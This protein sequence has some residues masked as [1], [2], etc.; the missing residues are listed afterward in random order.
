M[1]RLIGDEGGGLDRGDFFS[2]GFG[3]EA[4]IGLRGLNGFPETERIKEV[5]IT[6]HRPLFP[7]C[8]NTHFF[9]TSAC[10]WESTWERMRG[11]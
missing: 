4:M 2:L 10:A 3:L 5:H 7:P 9:P 11:S 6:Q 8:T 1:F